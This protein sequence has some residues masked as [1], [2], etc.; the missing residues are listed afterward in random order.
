M[1]SSKS[2]MAGAFVTLAVAG[3]FVAL[4]SKPPAAAPRPER[5]LADSSRSGPGGLI[6][7]ESM[8]LGAAPAGFTTTVT[9][10]GVPSTWTVTSDAT[11]PSETRALVQSSRDDHGFHFPLCILDATVARDVGVSVRFKTVGGVMNR[12]GGIVLRFQD[13][14]HY[15]VARFNSLEDN[16]GFYEYDGP[17][18]RTL[19]THAPHLRI[20]EEEWH[21]LRVEAR[22]ARFKVWYDGRLLYEIE[23]HGIQTAG[24]VGLWTKS[25]SVTYFDDLKIENLDEQK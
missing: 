18:H 6:D 13:P 10:E 5:D 14:A 25:D 3:G 22:G 12:S 23:D 15:Y 24:K 1:L 2:W 21:T 8:P 4:P 19:K 9:G 17:G 16:V 11:A 7:F 20:L